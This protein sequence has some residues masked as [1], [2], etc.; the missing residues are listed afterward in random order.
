M[1]DSDM[2]IRGKTI[3]HDSNNNITTAEGGDDFATANWGDK[4]APKKLTAKTIKA[5][6]KD[7]KTIGVAKSDVDNVGLGQDVE[8]IEASDKVEVIFPN[9]VMTASYCKS[10]GK[11]INCTGNVTIIAGKNKVSGEYGSFDLENDRYEI[12]SSLDSTQV[13][14]ILYKD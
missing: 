14:A 12:S 1:A 9:R 10:V 7:S 8:W 4:N 13:E 5:K 2:V 11:K 6:M 3:R